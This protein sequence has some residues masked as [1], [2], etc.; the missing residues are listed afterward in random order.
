MIGLSLCSSQ[1]AWEASCWE[2]G[3]TVEEQALAA[4]VVCGRRGWQEVLGVGSAQALY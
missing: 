2:E 1:L 3:N 4:G